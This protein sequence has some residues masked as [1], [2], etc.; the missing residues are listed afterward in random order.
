MPKLSYILDKT[1]RRLIDDGGDADADGGIVA[2]AV[3]SHLPFWRFH[4][5]VFSQLF[6]RRPFTR[7][8]AP[9][10]SAAFGRED[11]LALASK[12]SSPWGLVASSSP[13]ACGTHTSSSKYFT[14]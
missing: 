6:H 14:V 10:A 11:P 2:A 9:P 5:V 1:P 7:G 3:T 8:G 4:C 12:A 13:Y